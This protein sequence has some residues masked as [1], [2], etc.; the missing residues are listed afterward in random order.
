MDLSP[1][2]KWEVLGPDAEALIQASITRDARRLA[3]GQVVYTAVCNETGGMID[4]ATV[5][6]IADDNFRFIGGDAYDGV[7][8]KALAERARPARRGSSRRP[9]SCT[10]SPSRARGAA[11]SSRSSSGRRR[12]SRSSRS[13]SGSASSSAG[14]A[15]YDGIPLVVSRTGYSGE[16]GYE[17][18]CHPD[19]GPAVWD[20]VMA[21]GA[22]KGM[23]PARPRRARHAAHRVRPD[24]RRLRVRRPG[25]PVR[26]RRSASR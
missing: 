10:T 25:R 14:S 16:L 21:A 6:R 1:L 9:T 18:F 2:R 26:G 12:P 8:L 11:R 24:L 3:V 23:H 20:A 7:H 5:F 4:D 22:P 19:D 17:I 15:T 13:S